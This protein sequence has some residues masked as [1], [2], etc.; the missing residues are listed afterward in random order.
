MVKILMYANAYHHLR[1]EF[2]K[3]RDW[4][5]M[6]MGITATILYQ[7]FAS[8]YVN[9]MFNTVSEEVDKITKEISQ[10]M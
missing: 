1:G 4:A 9:E 5:M 3:V 8:K 10:M 7:K 2:M 6:G